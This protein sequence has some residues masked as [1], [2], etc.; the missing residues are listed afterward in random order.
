[1]NTSLEAEAEEPSVFVYTNGQPRSDIP[2]DVTH[3]RI[4][5]SSA[6]TTLQE[7]AFQNCTSLVEVQ[8]NHLIGLQTIGRRAFEN[9]ICLQSISL[10][11]S[12]ETLKDSSFAWCRSLATVHYL[13]KGL[14]CIGKSAFE[15]AGLTSITVPSTVET[16][17][18]R[19]FDGCHLV[20]T[21][22]LADSN[23]G[24]ILRHIGMRAF[25]SCARLTEVR[26]PSTIE[27]LDNGAFAWCKSLCTI[28][29]PHGLRQISDNLLE[30]CLALQHISLP[31]T[32][33]TI[34]NRAFEYCTALSEI[35][36]PERLKVIGFRSFAGCSALESVLFPSSCSLVSIG[37]AA[38]AECHMLTDV[39]L[40]D[41]LTSLGGFAFA[42]CHSLR[43]ANVPSTVRGIETGT[44]QGCFSLTEVELVEGLEV[45]GDIVFAFCESL[46]AI[47][48]PRSLYMIGRAFHGCQSLLGVE[49]PKDAVLIM[50]F[51]PP[52]F[53]KCSSLVTVSIPSSMDE[54]MW[55]AFSDCKMLQKKKKCQQDGDD[56]PK[57]RERFQDLPVHNIC[58]HA[59]HTT[60][61]DL[62]EA[63]DSATDNDRL[64]DDYGMTP[65][66]VVST[67]S[68]LRLD[69]FT[70]LLDRYPTTSKILWVR[71]CH[72]KTM[73][74]YLMIHR[75]S[76]KAIP[77]IKTALQR[78]LSC[79]TTAWA[80]E[81]WRFDLIHRVESM[82][83]ADDITLR[84][85]QL[86]EILERLGHYREM[87]ATSIIE[88]A[89][90][91]MA[92]NNNNSAAAAGQLSPMD[93]ASY[94]LRCGADVVL[95]NVMECLWNGTRETVYWI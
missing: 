31:S 41:G 84:R 4:V 12:V 3:V 83:W 87:E 92:M 34:G 88:L 29:L 52:C 24:G 63:L 14:R 44:F 7:C 9:C 39:Q 21:I 55:H 18:D 94:R 15:G 69:M 11:A 59:S 75:S 42:E 28:H 8:L 79:W 82:S 2:R 38:F 36:L 1:M 78:A 26:I 50:T 71:D 80:L 90:W 73:M 62:S 25:A 5:D 10:P 51:S 13:N 33:E 49:I 40:P 35:N 70:L 93:R 68:K 22:Q 19:A 64:V 30:R 47:A 23:N 66:H 20:T 43:H 54:S 95:S 81:E 91:K 32:V 86:D 37:D 48:F 67:S 76:N 89:L 45:I 27:T 56:A 16:I 72:G 6:T 46:S 61:E 53:S 77:L 17:G 60:L 65:C 85:E 58:Y 57:V 74:D